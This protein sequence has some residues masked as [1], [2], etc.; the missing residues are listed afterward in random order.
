MQQDIKACFL[1]SLR[2]E[3]GE[4]N[5]QQQH[6]ETIVAAASV[7]CERV[8]FE[9]ETIMPTAHGLFLVK[10]YSDLVD[11]MAE[12]IVMISTA[13]DHNFSSTSSPYVRVHSECLTGEV[14]GSLKCDCGPQLN[15]TLDK[16]NKVG[17]LVIYLRGHEGRSIGLINKLRTYK[18][19]EKDG[20]DTLDANLALGFPSDARKYDAAAAILSDLGITSIRLL[21]N[22]P[23]KVKQLE[24]HGITVV[25]RVPLI[26]GANIFNES[27]F[28]TKRDRMNH[29]LPRSTDYQTKLV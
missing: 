5:K 13:S 8:R 26:V 16:I 7:K 19:Q 1:G 12:H 25:E 18:L 27:Y 21:T 2:D 17:G 9:V 24:L 28:D 23:D 20:L 4:L 22:N 6:V 29:I 3:N 15:A 11:T 14:F 10:A